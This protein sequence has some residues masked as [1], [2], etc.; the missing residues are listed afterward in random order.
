[1]DDGGD[2]LAK[3]DLE[4]LGGEV[5]KKTGAGRDSACSLEVKR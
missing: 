4:R 5:D 3:L 1:M 2:G